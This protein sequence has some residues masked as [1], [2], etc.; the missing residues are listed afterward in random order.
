MC[1]GGGGVNLKGG[2]MASSLG[3]TLADRIAVREENGERFLLSLDPHLG[4]ETESAHGIE[5]HADD[6]NGGKRRVS[7]VCVTYGE[8]GVDSAR[9]RSGVYTR[10]WS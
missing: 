10:V 7:G 2:P 6:R 5:E 9:L 4:G 3:V 8:Y 1:V